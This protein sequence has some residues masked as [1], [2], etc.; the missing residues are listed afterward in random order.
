MFFNKETPEY[1]QWYYTFATHYTVKPDS[2]A[3]FSRRIIPKLP[4]NL[5]NT[6][7]AIEIKLYTSSEHK[8]RL[9]PTAL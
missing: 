1:T 6:T 7:V 2:N 3:L 4:I 9:S 8:T 5:V